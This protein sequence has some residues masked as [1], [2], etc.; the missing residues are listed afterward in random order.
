MV[1]QG[2]GS[3]KRRAQNVKAVR[4]L[5]VDL[6]GAPLA[7]IRTAELPPQAII[8]S[9]PG[10]FHAYWRVS[11]CPLGAFRSAQQH[12]A[13]RFGGDESVC[14]LPRVMRLPGFLHLKAEPFLSR[15]LECNPLPAYEF[16]DWQKALGLIRFEQPSPANRIKIGSRN[17]TMFALACGFRRQGL[18]P[19][20]ALARI[21]KLNATKCDL[22][23]PDSEIRALVSSAYSGP[24]SGFTIIPNVLFDSQEYKSIS[25]E[26]RNVVD[27]CYRMVGV[28]G[29]AEIVLSHSNFRSHFS[30][31]AF[32]RYRAEIIESGLVIQT[33]ANSKPQSGRRPEAARFR[34]RFEHSPTSG[35]IRA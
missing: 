25:P 32:Y 10:R 17:S 23:L 15:V 12:L 30:K 27:L 11:G 1:N 5:F 7:P 6:D 9:S 21:S 28:S 16:G 4:C 35:T 19:Q 14:D 3:S 29:T 24:A 8:E 31:S 33:K 2:D 34:L 13:K 26:A 20:E 18:D 22:P